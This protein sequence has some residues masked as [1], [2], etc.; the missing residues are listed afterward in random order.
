MPTGDKHEE[1]AKTFMTKVSDSAK[2][3]AESGTLPDINLKPAVPDRS[4]FLKINYS[5]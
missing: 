2:I 4:E 1:D 5:S 3:N